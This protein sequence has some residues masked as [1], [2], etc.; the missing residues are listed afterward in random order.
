M[1]ISFMKNLETAH[2]H[3]NQ[4][5]A[6]IWSIYSIPAL[7]AAPIKKA[8]LLDKSLIHHQSHHPKLLSILRFLCESLM[9]L[10]IVKKAGLVK[11][12]RLKMVLHVMEKIIHIFQKLL[13][14]LS[15]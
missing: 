3:Q 1:Q 2:I 12:F 11:Q 6:N 4:K 14:M 8:P 13:V 5:A 15:I 9:Q 10:K 7:V